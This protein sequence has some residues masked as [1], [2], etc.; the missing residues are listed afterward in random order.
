MMKLKDCSNTLLLFDFGTVLTGLSK[1]RCIEAL[2]K[3]GCGRIAYYVDECRQEDLF[4]DLEIGG[5]I[6]DFC[7]EARLKSAYTD[8]T[9]VFHPCTATDEQ[10]CWAWNEL[11]T[12]I[13]V[14]KLR[15]VYHLHHD[16]GY[17]TAILSNTNKIHWDKALQDYFTI[18]GLQMEDYF[19]EIFM[20][21]LLQKVKPDDEIYSEVKQ[22]VSGKV[23]N[24]LFIDDS[25]KNCKAAERNGIHA[26]HDA[27]GDKWMTT[28]MPLLQGGGKAAIIGNF[29]GVHKGHLSVINRLHTLAAERHLTP[30][31]ITFDCHPSSIFQ[32][33]F[34]PE[35]LATLTERLNLLHSALHTPDSDSKEK[36]VLL[37]H[38]TKEFAAIPARQFMEEELRDKLNVRL[39]LLGYDNRFGRYNPDEDFATYRQYG[40]ELGIEVL[41]SDP[42]DVGEV[43]VSSSLIRG[44]VKRGSIEEANECLGY[45]YSITG[46][47]V[48]G[49]EE[50]RKIGFPTA[51]ILP[52]EGKLMPPNGVYESEVTIEGENKVRRGMTNIGTR[53]T[54]NGTDVTIE[55][56]IL[57]FIGNIYGK[58][59]TVRLKRMIRHEMQFD[60]PEALR[61]QIEKDRQQCN[62]GMA[63]LS[64]IT[65]Q[66][67]NR[68]PKPKK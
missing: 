23:E 67:E 55:T 28:L 57:G 42:L 49:Y 19:D 5:S 66:L 21:Y 50:G 8:E 29:D 14:E 2:K 63:A 45:P 37:L 30:L 31:A 1:Q 13:P 64:G 44:M 12:G 60:S 68:T 18:D 20:S 3:I 27:N 25:E 43:R 17:R 58:S 6:E 35:F 53:P 52:P 33:D 48:H 47:V 16:L 10:I 39:L 41:M 46:T 7:N 26:F 56:N 4:H 36:D 51:N 24:I 59:I 40:K 34:H 54:Y 32:A 9:G 38:F 15:M 62:E 65:D 22:R 11:I 61:E